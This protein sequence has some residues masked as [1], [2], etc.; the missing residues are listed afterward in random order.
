MK[1]L[2]ESIQLKKVKGCLAEARVGRDELA[3]KV[4]ELVKSRARVL[5]DYQSLCRECLDLDRSVKTLK[6]FQTY[7]A[8]LKRSL[9]AAKDRVVVD[10]MP[11]NQIVDVLCNVVD[12]F[13][14]QSN[15]IENYQKLIEE[16][17]SELAENGKVVESTRSQIDQLKLEQVVSPL[18]IFIVV[19]TLCR[20]TVGSF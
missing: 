11:D 16:K 7:F 2:S 14:K 12:G 17:N 19:A 8:T 18:E 4:S 6:P 3:T 1:T 5:Q 20:L 10:A 9:L 15:E 13:V